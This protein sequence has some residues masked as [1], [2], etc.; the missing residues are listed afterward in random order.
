MRWKTAPLCCYFSVIHFHQLELK[1]LNCNPGHV[2]CFPPNHGCFLK[3]DLEKWSCFTGIFLSLGWFN[4]QL[5]G[6]ERAETERGKFVDTPRTETRPTSKVS[7]D[8]CPQASWKKKTKQPANTFHWPQGLLESSFQF[9]TKRQVFELRAY[10]WC[11]VTVNTYY[12][13]CFSIFFERFGRGMGRSR[14]SFVFFFLMESTWE[15]IP[16]I[17][18]CADR[19]TTNPRVS[20][21]VCV[22]LVFMYVTETCF[23]PCVE[24][25]NKVELSTI[26]KEM[27]PY[28]QE[29][30][31][32]FFFHPEIGGIYFTPWK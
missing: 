30:V 23:F 22:G 1:Q 26:G 10:R 24:T 17:F 16:D 6:G 21:G 13:P 11:F 27:R 28:P 2:Y 29:D 8:S 20:L 5:D 9:G 18:C 31:S 19:F 3:S 14:S 4:H 15:N 7:L 32:L 12:Q 25:A